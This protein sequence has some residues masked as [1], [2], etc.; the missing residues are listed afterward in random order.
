MEKTS[1]LCTVCML[2]TTFSSELPGCNIYTRRKNKP[3]VGSMAGFVHSAVSIQ[4]VVDVYRTRSRVI[5]HNSKI[6]LKG[7][8]V[9]G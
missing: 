5:A 4:A 7:E 6:K 8:S 9:L 1:D 2:S 3:L